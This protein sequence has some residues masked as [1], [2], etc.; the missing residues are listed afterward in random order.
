MLEEKDTIIEQR[1]Y[2]KQE[3]Y[4]VEACV[5]AIAKERFTSRY[6]INNQLNKG[7][8]TSKPIEP[9]ISH[10]EAQRAFAVEVKIHLRQILHEGYHRFKIAAETNSGPFLLHQID[11]EYFYNTHADD[12]NNHQNNKP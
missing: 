12:G 6:W 11:I 7:S 8:C 2:T 4:D 5:A 3:F 10:A 1:D 9:D